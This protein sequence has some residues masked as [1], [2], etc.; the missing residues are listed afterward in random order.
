M[1]AARLFFARYQ[2]FFAR[3]MLTQ[4]LIMSRGCLDPRDRYGAPGAKRINRTISLVSKAPG[5]GR[6]QRSMHRH[7][8]LAWAGFTVTDK[9]TLFET[10]A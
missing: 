7:I 9:L 2:A 1:K 5:D 8:P 6:I 4:D 3:Y 10:N